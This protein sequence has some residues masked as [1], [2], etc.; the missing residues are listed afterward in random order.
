MSDSNKVCIT[1][2]ISQDEISSLSQSIQQSVITAETDTLELLG[3]RNKISNYLVESYL[4]RPV[5]E[6]VIFYLLLINA[7]KQ[8]E[9]RVQQINQ[10][11]PELADNDALK[12]A[13]KFVLN[14]EIIRQAILSKHK[15]GSLSDSRVNLLANA[16]I[17]SITRIMLPT[18]SLSEI[19][20][21]LYTDDLTNGVTHKR[22]FASSTIFDHETGRFLCYQLEEQVLLFLSQFDYTKNGKYTALDI[23]MLL[24]FEERIDIYLYNLMKINLFRKEVALTFK[25]FK[26]L[27]DISHTNKYKPN[28]FY[29]KKICKS[30]ERL[31]S[32]PSVELSIS[33]NYVSC[34]KRGPDRN[35]NC[36]FEFKIGLKPSYKTGLNELQKICRAK[37]DKYGNSLNIPDNSFLAAIRVKNGN[38]SEIIG[39]VKS[40]IEIY[41]STNGPSY[42]AE[43][44]KLLASHITM[45]LEDLYKSNHFFERYLLELRHRTKDLYLDNRKNK[46]V[47]E[48]SSSTT[49]STEFKN[50]VDKLDVKTA[51]ILYESKRYTDENNPIVVVD[52]NFI[53]HSIF[54]TNPYL[55]YQRKADEQKYL[56]LVNE[57]VSVSQSFFGIT[58]QKTDF[59]TYLSE[60][61]FEYYFDDNFLLTREMLKKLLKKDKEYWRE[62]TSQHL[63]LWKLASQFSLV[64]SDKLVEGDKDAAQ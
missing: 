43:N 20:K 23:L 4:D 18:A 25:D 5:T 28:D 35:D 39:I 32:D 33:T 51:E 37:Q 61:L 22:I 24:K 42:H 29:T 14:F 1:T 44:L 64:E 48:D 11:Q 17:E 58:G 40:K 49:F 30:I 54:E 62:K 31:N 53:R 57:A 9:L 59:Q 45:A 19:N 55:K 50:V 6:Q 27:S 16:H 10:E 60:L 41:E 56:D 36:R 63:R 38:A 13:N 7:G 3:F 26:T 52:Y 47:I 2:G 21:T 8:L 12:Q 46:I 15:A 34:N